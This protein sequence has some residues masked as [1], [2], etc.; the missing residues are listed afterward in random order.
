MTQ[1]LPEDE[2]FSVE[3]SKVPR[4]V[5]SITILDDTA[6]TVKPLGSK[7]NEKSNRRS[8]C[9]SREKRSSSSSRFLLL[10]AERAHSHASVSVYVIE[11]AGSS[12]EPKRAVSRAGSFKITPNIQLLDA[13]G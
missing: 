13:T 1:P 6:D 3:L 8:C 10:L 12:D 9:L 4:R 11:T 5:G 7:G 2:D